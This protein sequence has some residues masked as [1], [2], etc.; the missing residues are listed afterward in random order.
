MELE[1]DEDKRQTTLRERGLD[2]ADVIHFDAGSLETYEDLRSN[3]GEL[4]FNAFGYLDGVLCTYCWT[5]RNGK[6][7]IVSMRKMNERERKAYKAAKG[8]PSDT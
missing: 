3:Y 7:R 2:F 5:L 1:W 6:M 8:E 4:R